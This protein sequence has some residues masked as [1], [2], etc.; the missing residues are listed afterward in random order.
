[1][2]A[3]RYTRQARLAEVGEAGQAR[4]AQASIA[5]RGQGARGDIEA[6]YLRAA[7]VGHVAIANTIEHADVD[8]SPLAS[9]SLDP[10][11]GDVAI[12]A[13]RALDALRR[14]LGVR[15]GSDAS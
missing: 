11:A 7:G 2:S 1:M 3:I 5:V 9:L 4:I 6:T 12:G 8:D 14:V 15:S 10:S 13:W